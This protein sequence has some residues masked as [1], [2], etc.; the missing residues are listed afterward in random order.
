MVIPPGTSHLSCCFCAWASL[1]HPLSVCSPPGPEGVTCQ[2]L[3]TL[4]IQGE[5]DL[6]LF[7]QSRSP[8]PAAP[9]LPSCFLE[10]TSPASGAVTC[11]RG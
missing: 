1:S 8:D 2:G 5:L 7:L 9:A 4:A 11:A 3:G 6:S 10:P